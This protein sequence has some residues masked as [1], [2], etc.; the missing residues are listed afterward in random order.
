MHTTAK[1]RIASLILEVISII[2]VFYIINRRDKPGY[3]VT[4]IVLILI[5]PLFGGVLYLMFRLQSSVERLHRKFAKY[6]IQAQS[7]LKQDEELFKK[8]KKESSDIAVQAQYI[9]KTVGYPIYRNTEVEY[10]SSGENYFKRLTEELEKA[11]RFI[12]LEYFII[13]PGIML[14]TILG[15]LKEKVAAGVD[16][17]II[18]DDM[19]CVLLYPTSIIE[20]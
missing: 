4:W 15:I 2:V 5:F 14:D 13:S 1:F 12:F 3:K 9:C 11:K 7:I 18:Y 6:D 10:L 16:V 8:I 20:P 17:R 19:G